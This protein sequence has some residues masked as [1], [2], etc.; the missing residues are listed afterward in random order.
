MAE[1]NPTQQDLF[2]QGPATEQ[3]CPECLKKF[4]PYNNRKNV[5][6]C[7]Y[8]CGTRHSV[9][10]RRNARR[11]ALEAARSTCPWCQTEFVPSR[12]N[13]AFCGAACYGQSNNAKKRGRVIS[14]RAPVVCEICKASFT[15]LNG[16]NVKYCSIPCRQKAHQ[17]KAKLN[18]KANPGKNSQYQRDYRRRN[19]HAVRKHRLK[20]WYGITPEQF[21]AMLAAQGHR[22]AI[23][24]T[25]LTR[26]CLDHDHGPSNAVRGVLCT[27]CNTGLGGFRDNPEFLRAAITYLERCRSR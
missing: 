23:C 14:A 22:C 8:E 17:E 2:P 19:N 9:R 20:N 21:D 16:N 27:L 18:R 26:P 15:P 24:Q 10:R 11:D 1:A 13:Q 12:S 7:S 4:V 5:V 3:T 6:F 25:E